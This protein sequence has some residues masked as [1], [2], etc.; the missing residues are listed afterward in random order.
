MS[1]HTKSVYSF[2]KV[3]KE[4][5]YAFM[6][7]D[8]KSGLD[9]KKENPIGEWGRRVKTDS[10]GVLKDIVY[11]LVELCTCGFISE[12]TLEYIRSGP[13]TQSDVYSYWVS[14]GREVNKHTCE[15]SVYRDQDK[16]YEVVGGQVLESLYRDKN[17]VESLKKIKEVVDREGRGERLDVLLGFDWGVQE[18][19][20]EDMIEDKDFDRL[21][22]F[23]S[24]YGI[25]R[26]NDEIKKVEK[27][28]PYIKFLSEKGDMDEVEKERYNKIL[29]L[30]GG[31]RPK[32][33]R[34][35]RGY[36]KDI[37]SDFKYRVTA[38]KKSV[39]SVDKEN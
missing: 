26:L 14:E 10:S 16:F 3:M 38:N 29:S 5:Y 2:T 31:P 9:I 1:K 35:G 30:V 12:F 24:R 21:Y 28:I 18:W 22:K 34:I 37:F 23:A 33:R 27:L 6:D 4:V 8:R 11:S 7:F 19:S 36:S 20:Q 39:D 15:V 25:N 32:R 13:M 17:R